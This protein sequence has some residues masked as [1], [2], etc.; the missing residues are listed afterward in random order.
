MHTVCVHTTSRRGPVIIPIQKLGRLGRG[1][2]GSD[3][4]KVTGFSVAK[5]SSLPAG[6]ASRACSLPKTRGQKDVLGLM[7]CGPILKFFTSFK[8]GPT[9]SFCISCGKLCGWS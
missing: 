4:P 6:L 8:Q 1:Q 9:F 7:L 2:S 5:V 3:L